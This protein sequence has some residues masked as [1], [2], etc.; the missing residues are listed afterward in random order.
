VENLLKLRQIYFGFLFSSFLYFAVVILVLGKNTKKF[1]ISFFDEV[2]FIFGSVV[3]AVLYFFKR[4]ERFL[5][6]KNL[7]K[8]SIIGQIPLL[9]GFFLAIINKNYLFLISMFP[10]FF[11][12][13]LIILPTEK[14]IRG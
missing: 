9:I 12:G 3:P 4:K 5:N 7:I 13:Y 2:L 6:Q 8:F 1:E 10:V 14:N 11:L